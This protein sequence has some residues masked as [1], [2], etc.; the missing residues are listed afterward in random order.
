[1]ATGMMLGP[2]R[3]PQEG[4]RADAAVATVAAAARAR[5]VLLL[6]L[7][8]PLRLA[9]TRLMVVPVALGLMLTVAG[10]LMV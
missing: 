4:Y 7:A 9:V 3:R 5:H 10:L 2:L 1:M 6:L 8:V